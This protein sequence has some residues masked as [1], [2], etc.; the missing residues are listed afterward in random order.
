[1]LAELR[2]IHQL[3]DRQAPAV[4]RPS[5]PA[6]TVRMAVAQGWYALGRDDAPLTIVE[7]SDYQCP[8][9]RRFHLETFPELKKNYVDTGRVRFVSR[10]LPLD[11]HPNALRAAEAARCA[12]DQKKYWELRDTLIANAAELGGEALIRHARS[13]GLDVPL[14]E[15]C[16]DNHVHKDAIERD[17]SDA[18]ALQVSGT[19]TFVL[20]R[21]D[22]TSI[23]GLRL[24]GAQP[25]S[26]FEAI[27]GKLLSDASSPLSMPQHRP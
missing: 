24:V 15:R 1:M 11:F 13:V 20:G 26:A 6:P 9:C 22:R 18:R 4:M 21:T 12:G 7:F 5:P 25:Y 19:P 2:A 27:I 16:L 14:F 8:Y 23:E 10:D 3:L 17:I